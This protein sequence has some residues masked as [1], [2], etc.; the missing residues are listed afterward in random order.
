MKSLYNFLLIIAVL[1]ILK[2][3]SARTPGINMPNAISD[4]IAIEI[5]GMD[6]WVL[7]RGEDRSNPVL[8]WL[9][10][11]P[12]AAQMPVHRA[13]NKE[14][15]KEFVVVHWDQ[16]G[17]GKSNH[18][19][20]S[21][22]TMTLDRFIEDVHEMTQYLKERFGRE[23]IFLLGHSWGTQLGILTVQR[24][25]DNYHAFISVAQVVHPQRAEEISYDWLKQQVEQHGSRRQK[26]KLEQLGPPLYDEHDRY[27]TFAKMKDAFGGSMDIGMGRLAWIS[28]GAKEYTFGDYAKWLRGA[29][30]G[31]G[32]MW[33]ELR[34]FDLFRDVPSIEVPVWFIVGE[35]DYNT[36]VVLVEEYYRFVEAPEGKT[37]IVMSGV[38]HA[39]FMGDPE[40]FHRELTGI[41]SNVIN[42]N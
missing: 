9:H 25:P 7:I 24:Y 2:G 32:P 23:K 42:L 29:N 38:A 8:L 41:K 40:R 14:L 31:C 4:L 20:F 6:Q 11:G 1:V 34:D 19:G 28:F 35:N 26:R 3:C 27:V 22:E 13:F 15:E 33:E 16:R 10:G 30:R 18:S 37:L 21:E 5:G 12:G 36:P 39:P 17:A